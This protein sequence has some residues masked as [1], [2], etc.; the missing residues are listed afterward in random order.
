MKYVSG[1]I[2]HYNENGF[3]N[4]NCYVFSIDKNIVH[5]YYINDVGLYQVSCTLQ[6]FKELFDIITDI[7]I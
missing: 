7:F 5:Y 3:M 6:P 4:A 2:T 1:V